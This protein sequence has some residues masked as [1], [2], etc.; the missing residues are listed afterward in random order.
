[1]IFLVAPITRRKA[2]NAKFYNTTHHNVCH[3]HALIENPQLSLGCAGSSR[4]NE[5][6]AILDGAVDISNHGANIAEAVRL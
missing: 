6:S 5:D 3:R 4:I 1:M 2:G